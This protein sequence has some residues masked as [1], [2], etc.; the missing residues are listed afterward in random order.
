MAEI[1]QV[2]FYF[3]WSPNCITCTLLMWIW[4]SSGKKTSTY[5]ND[6]RTCHTLPDLPPT[7]ATLRP[8]RLP[9]P[10]H[11]TPPGPSR[12]RDNRLPMLNLEFLC[13]CMLGARTNAPEDAFF[14][15]KCSKIIIKSIATVTRE[16]PNATTSMATTTDLTVLGWPIFGSLVCSLDVTWVFASLARLLALFSLGFF[17][18]YFLLSSVYLFCFSSSQKNIFVFLHYFRCFEAKDVNKSELMSHSL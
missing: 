12:Q 4:Q 8:A 6:D 16:L 15:R 18:P 11:P 5:G 13:V 2:P 14:P 7:T 1:G 10:P 3:N 17:L 9:F